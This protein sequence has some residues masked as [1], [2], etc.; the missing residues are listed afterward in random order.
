MENHARAWEDW[1][2]EGPRLLET[3]SRRSSAMMARTRSSD[4]WRLGFFAQ[5]GRKNEPGT[6]VPTRVR[7]DSTAKCD[8]WVCV[9][10]AANFHRKRDVQDVWIWSIASAPRC[11]EQASVNE[12]DTCR[13]RQE[14]CTSKRRSK[15]RSKRLSSRTKRF[16]WKGWRRSEDMRRTA[17]ELQDTELAESRTVKIVEIQEKRAEARLP[18]A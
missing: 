1:D 6:A 11:C 14:H 5:R 4:W 18:G 16:L 15:R 3:F 12:C 17:R 8:E 9:W 10:R 2:R 7:A 13:V